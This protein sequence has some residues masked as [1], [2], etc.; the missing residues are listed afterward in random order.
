MARKIKKFFFFFIHVMRW[1][2]CFNKKIQDNQSLLEIMLNLIF[3]LLQDLSIFKKFLKSFKI[4]YI[5][6]GVANRNN[7]IFKIE[8]HRKSH[9]SNT[10]SYYYFRKVLDVEI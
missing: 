10:N 5:Y 2:F 4:L 3:C 8:I 6:E 9:C 7:I 1:L